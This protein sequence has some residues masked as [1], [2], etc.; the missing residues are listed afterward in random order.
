MQ[1]YNKFHLLSQ[2]Q[3]AKVLI[4]AVHLA[5]I[6]PSDQEQEKKILF[7]RQYG[8]KIT[9]EVYVVKLSTLLKR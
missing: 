2:K 7:Y 3:V 6:D 5:N 4:Q 8:F 9:Q 1:Y